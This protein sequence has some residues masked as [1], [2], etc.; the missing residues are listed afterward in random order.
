HAG[1]QDP[2]VKTEYVDKEVIVDN[3]FPCSDPANHGKPEHECEQKFI[4]LCTDP[5]N[6]GNANHNCE[7]VFYYPDAEAV[8]CDDAY[9]CLEKTHDSM[10]DVAIRGGNPENYIETAL[11]LWFAR[12]GGL[13]DLDDI[14]ITYGDGFGNEIRLT[15]YRTERSLSPCLLDEERQA[16]FEAA[17]SQQS[18]SQE[19][20][21]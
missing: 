18:Q 6:H 13:H 5:A 16:A 17:F 20:G 19:H 2:E 14:Y 15:E 4:E 1:C 11:N 9:G 12:N 8:V 10:Y 3:P 21:L 7:K